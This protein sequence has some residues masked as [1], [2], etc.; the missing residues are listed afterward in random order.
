MIVLLPDGQEPSVDPILDILKNAKSVAVVGISSKPFRA[1]YGV[2]E[3]LLRAGYKIF[4]VNP[5]ETEVHGLPCYAN[6]EAV[7]ETVDIVDVFRKA[8][9]VPPVVDSAIAVSA[10]VLWLQEGILHE[11]AGEKARAA[12]LT[13]VMD[14]CMLK[15]HRRRMRQLVA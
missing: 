3:Y 5:N 2:S 6:L 11:E 14:A 7:P 13:V 12:G 15:E 4:P 1:S 9:D 10:K 8:E